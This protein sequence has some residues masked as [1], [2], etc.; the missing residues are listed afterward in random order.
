LEIAMLKL[1]KSLAA[2]YSDTRRRIRQLNTSVDAIEEELVDEHMAKQ[3]K[4]R[5][6]RTIMSAGIDQAREVLSLT[7]TE[8][9]IE[10]AC[11]RLAK[12]HRGCVMIYARVGTYHVKHCDERP[13][14]GMDWNEN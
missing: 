7:G 13:E 12:R 9:E 6:T 5:I 11:A 14:G 4:P 8:D 10:A 1:L 3:T 2:Q